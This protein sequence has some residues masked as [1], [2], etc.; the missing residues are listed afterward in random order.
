MLGTASLALGHE[1]AAAALAGT[2]VTGVR[3]SGALLFLPDACTLVG[4][5]TLR[6]GDVTAGLRLLAAADAVRKRTGLVV[7]YRRLRALSAD[8]TAEARRAVGHPD[9]LSAQTEGRRL[10]ARGPSAL[11]RLCGS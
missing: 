7:L 10:G 8:R 3:S 4:L 9:Y 11:L 2:V 6:A 5:T 1:H